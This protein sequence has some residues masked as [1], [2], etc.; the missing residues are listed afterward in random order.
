MFGVEGVSKN[1]LE[2]KTALLKANFRITGIF[3]NLAFFFNTL[4]HFFWV[5]I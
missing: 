1:T 2:L 5:F 4:E 3:I